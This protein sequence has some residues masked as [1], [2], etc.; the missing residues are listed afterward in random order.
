MENKVLAIV[1]GNE[2]T[3]ND[4]NEIIARYPEQQMI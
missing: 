4:L 3:S 2:I 1:A